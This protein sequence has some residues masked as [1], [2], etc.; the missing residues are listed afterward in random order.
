MNTSKQIIIARRQSV[1]PFWMRCMIWGDISPWKSLARNWKQETSGFH[2][3]HSTIRC[4]FSQSCVSL[5]DI[6]SSVRPNM[7]HAMIMRIISIRFVLCVELLQRLNHRRLQMRS[8]TRSSTG[9]AGMVFP[10]IYMESAHAVRLSFHVRKA[11]QQLRG[12]VKNSH[13]SK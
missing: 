10:Y 12:K 7:K 13:K 3:P 6:V 8:A 4:G 9:S 1:M 11:R 2:V 5:S